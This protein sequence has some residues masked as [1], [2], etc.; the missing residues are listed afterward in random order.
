MTTQTDWQ[1]GNITTRWAADL[2]AMEWNVGYD[3]IGMSHLSLE[4][5]IIPVS[6]TKAGASYNPTGDTLQF[7]FM[8]TPTQVPQVSDWVAGVWETDSSNILYPYN[9]KCLVGPG[10]TITLGIGMYVIYL[11]ITDNPEVPVLVG[12]QL[13][14]S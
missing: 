5:V 12:G 6:V 3:T 10:G 8:P 9:A 2:P 14:I 4:Y 13:A 1:P 7:A 11:Q